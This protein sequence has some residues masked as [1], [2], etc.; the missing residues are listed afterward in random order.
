MQATGHSFDPVTGA[1]EVITDQGL[2]LGFSPEVFWASGLLH[3]RRGQRLTVVC[4]SLAS[5]PQ[6]LRVLRLGVQ[7][8]PEWSG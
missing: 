2:V 4:E 8:I 1:G 6:A 5:N 7:G 3:I